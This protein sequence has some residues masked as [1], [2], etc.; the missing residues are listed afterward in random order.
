MHRYNRR[1]RALVLF[2]CALLLAACS[3]SLSL[4]GQPINSDGRPGAPPPGG[5]IPGGPGTPVDP[6]QE[7]CAASPSSRV[8]RL[9]RTQYANTVKDLLK[10]DQDLTGDFLSDNSKTGYS[11]DA[12]DLVASDRHVRDYERAAQT[13]AESLMSSPE[14]LAAVLPC[15]RAEGLPCAEK[16]IE[17][18]GLK[19]FR[20]PLQPQEKAAF[21][22]LFKKAPTLFPVGADSFVAGVRLV[23]EAMLQTPEFLYRNELP[24]ND[25]EEATPLS[26]FELA[27]RL[28]YTLTDSMP[29]DTLFSAAASGTLVNADDVK[30]QGARLMGM[31]KGATAVMNF[32]HQWLR[33]DRS[34]QISRDDKKFPLYSKAVNAA[35]KEETERFVRQAIL[36]QKQGITQLLGADSVMVS[37][38]TAPLYGL[39]SPASGW[40][41][42]TLND[43]RRGLLGQLGYLAT[44]AYFDKTDPIHRGVML[45]QKILCT[46]LPAPSAEAAGTPE[47]PFGDRIVTRRQQVAAH[48]ETPGCISCHSFIN[49][50]GF[51]FEQF[52]AVGSVQSN[53]RG[54]PVDAS[55]TLKIDGAMVSFTDARG[56]VDVLAK[57]PQVSRCYAT[58]WFRFTQGREENDADRCLIESATSATPGDAPSLDAVTAAFIASP[59]FLNRPKGGQ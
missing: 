44:N 9:T 56:L 51:A 10:T 23:V 17:A 27:S 46:E 2:L 21:V 28:S 58:Q 45:H 4:I 20:R 29:D 57:S 24:D 34:L 32:H 39:P 42:A 8:L 12:Q 11:T 36:E 55:G 26:P 38:L 19:A 14:R 40:E 5:P 47:P 52:N 43:G 31:S 22:D 3:G 54:V 53:D 7:S 33:T 6:G 50:A 15:S 30:A 1:M 18:F 59:Q 13:L 48:T 41:K 49:P 16:F 25:T 35:L 37:A